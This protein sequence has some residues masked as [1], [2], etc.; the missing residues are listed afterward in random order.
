MKGRVKKTN[1]TMKSDKQNQ[2]K[3][4]LHRKKRNKI[5][6]TK[7]NNKE[8]KIQVLK[9]GKVKFVSA[10]GVSLLT[11]FWVC[12]WSSQSSRSFFLILGKT[13]TLLLILN[14][15]RGFCCSSWILQARK[16]WALLSPPPLS[17]VP[18]RMGAWPGLQYSRVPSF[19]PMPSEHCAAHTVHCIYVPGQGL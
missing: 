6:K 3:K 8:N 14:L 11:S 13:K 12:L 1:Q 2:K 4:K 9:D 17:C 10:V 16:G 18:E 15:P 5:I 7:N 19:R